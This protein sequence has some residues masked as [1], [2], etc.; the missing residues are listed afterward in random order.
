MV[1]DAPLDDRTVRWAVGTR[2]VKSGEAIR[3]S[4]K[5]DHSADIAERA[6]HIDDDRALTVHGTPDS[7]KHD[8]AARLPKCTDNKVW[9]PTTCRYPALP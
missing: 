9:F 6:I 5:V 4:L 8:V 7:S 3:L 2:M 1:L